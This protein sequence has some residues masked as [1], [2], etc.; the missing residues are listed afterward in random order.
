M[1]KLY[2]DKSNSVGDRVQDLDRKNDSGIEK[3]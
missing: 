3:I 1:K 2:R